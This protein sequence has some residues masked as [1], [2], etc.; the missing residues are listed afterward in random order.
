M[1]PATDKHQ[2]LTHRLKLY[3]GAVIE[4]GVKR[5][6]YKERSAMCKNLYYDRIKR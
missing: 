3:V 2:A 4:Q 1:G 5:R 6:T